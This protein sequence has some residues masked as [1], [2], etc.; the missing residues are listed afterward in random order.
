MIKTIRGKREYIDAQQRLEA[1]F[2]KLLEIK[3]REALPPIRQIHWETGTVMDST[4]L[5]S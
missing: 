5:V 4:K 2:G 1:S 3:A